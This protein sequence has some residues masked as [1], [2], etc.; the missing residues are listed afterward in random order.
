MLKY[1][2]YALCNCVSEEYV[3]SITITEGALYY[4][5][6][7]NLYLLIVRDEVVVVVVLSYT[8]LL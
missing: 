1:L 7:A 6:I 8:L 4:P 2:E 3:Y 5:C